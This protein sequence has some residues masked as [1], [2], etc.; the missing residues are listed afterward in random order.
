[1]DNPSALSNAIRRAYDP[2]TGTYYYSVLDVI[3]A[4]TGS[5]YPR[6]YWNELKR[7][8]T[9]SG[10]TV[11]NNVHPRKMVAADGKYYETNAADA[12]TILR[13][14]QSLSGEA[15]EPIKLWLARLALERLHELRHHPASA[16]PLDQLPMTIFA[17]AKPHK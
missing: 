2:A 15:G 17:E 4:I 10:C 1:M 6:R 5:A 3:A 14:I 7:K 9:A 13:L 11:Q 16:M 8:L 12:E